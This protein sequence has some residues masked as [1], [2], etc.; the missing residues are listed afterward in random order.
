MPMLTVVLVSPPRK[1]RRDFSIAGGCAR[2]SPARPCYS[3]SG[4]SAMNRRRRNAPDV[5]AA[6]LLANAAHQCCSRRLPAS[7]P[8]VS[9]TCFRLSRVD[10]HDRT[11]DAHSARDCLK[12]R[13]SIAENARMLYRPVR[14]SVS[15]TA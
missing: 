6:Q 15:D 1:S 10:H 12:A 8:C 7:C 4:S 13:C 9:L 11:A 14:S 3:V 5:G 2:P